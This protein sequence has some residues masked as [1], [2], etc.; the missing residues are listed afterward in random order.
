[1]KTSIKF[2]KFAKTLI[3]AS[4]IASAL[5]LAGCSSSEERE[6]RYLERARASFDAGD[7]EK[8]RVDIKNVLQI[9]A[10]NAQARL[11]FARLEERQQNWQ[12]MYANLSAAVEADPSLWEARVKLAELLVASNQ[13]N[14]ANEQ[15]DAV[16]A[17]VPDHPEALSV[18]AGVLF[19]QGKSA[20]AELLCKQI[21]EKNPGHITATGLLAA[22]YGNSDPA[23]A[24]ATVESGISS[25]PSNITLQLLRIQFLTQLGNTGEVVSAYQKLIANQPDALIYPMQLAAYLSGQG[26]NDD[27]EVVMREMLKRNPQSDQA[28][29]IMIDFLTRIDKPEDAL[30][31]LQGFVDNDP[32]NYLL[33]SALAK[34]HIA[35]GDPDKAEAVYLNIID[36]SPR[37]AQGI[38]ARNR[39]IELLL[40]RGERARADQLLA[41]NLDIEPEN[42]DALLIRA[43]L[44]LQENK[45]EDAI[46]DLRSVLRGAPNSTQALEL[47]GLAQ[48]RTGA[49]NLALDTYQQLLQ[50]NFSSVPGLTG[51]ARLLMAQ[52][53]QEDAAKM[54]EQ[55]FKVA[56]D[57][58]DVIRQY[59][60]VLTR[61]KQWDKAQAIAQDLILRQKTATFG[62]FLRGLILERQGDVA[63]SIEALENSLK[64]EPRAVESL[65]ALLSMYIR[66][67][68]A[69]QAVA[70]AENHVKQY[71][72]QIHAQELLAALYGQQ[73]RRADAE[74]LL[75]AIIDKQPTRVSAYRELSAVLIAEKRKEQAVALLEKGLTQTPDNPGLLLMLAELYQSM[76]SDAKALATYE[77]LEKL[78]PNSDI[79][80]NNLA[81]LL[82]EMSPSDENLQRAMRLTAHFE[83]SD[84]PTFLDTLGWIH[85]KSGNYA[86]AISL[87]EDAV[88]RQPTAELHY[89]LGIAYVRNNMIDKGREQLQLAI[90]DGSTYSWVRDAEQALRQTEQ[91][92]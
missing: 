41:E 77:Q 13:I 61:Q 35:L 81:M 5:H 62:H 75:T 53:K 33:R 71:P 36:K 54:L 14:Q 88:R 34:L 79:V 21:L 12:Q 91:T 82:V 1:M 19:R 15:I 78:L 65:Q 18:R 23:K 70:Y 56:P 32:D 7:Y 24:L 37:A 20:E 2:Q 28:K 85:V 84:N 8:A 38:D 4:L 47:L 3:S 80:R 66:N 9:N 60:D 58:I 90:K 89:H 92:N 51:A 31:T 83:R 49:A 45:A 44:L 10:S 55:A 69:A 72:D 87:L 42:G 67:D 68:Q 52:N 74:R 27:A 43:R 11:L 25:N 59:V 86:Q 6:A 22:I 73:G 50:L 30:T 16:I 76:G 46:A 57:N 39:L 40:A 29:L 48:E 17:Q 26:R 63:G 64:M